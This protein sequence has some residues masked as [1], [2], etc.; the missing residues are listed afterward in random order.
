[1]TLRPSCFDSGPFSGA[2][3]S[4]E[5]TMSNLFALPFSTWWLDPR[6]PVPLAKRWG[7]FAEYLLSRHRQKNLAPKPV[8]ALRYGTMAARVHWLLLRESLVSLHRSWRSLPRLA[9]VSDGSWKK[10]EF[11][12]A[13]SFWPGPIEILMPE[14]ITGPLAKAGQNALVELAGQHPLGLKLACVIHL[15]RAQQ[16]L[17]VDSDILWFSDPESILAPL[18]DV[19]GPTSSVETGYSFNQDIVQRHCPEGFPSPHINSGCVYLKGELCAPDL[20]QAMLA[21]ALEQPKNNYNEQTIIA[22]AVNKVGRRFSPEFCLVD[23]DDAA[24]WRRRS[25][26]RRNH[27]AC[28]Y[29]HWM[30]HQFHRDALRLRIQNNSR[31]AKATQPGKSS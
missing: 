24:L 26:W 19:A 23:F 28:H 13:F 20:L 4:G 18:R 15:A 6:S 22:V 5:L 11:Q 25:P 12:Q 10:E 29:V 31:P 14:D 9:V 1:M 3:F 8:S 30:R 27:Y 2:D 21:T 7:G 16:I 17:F